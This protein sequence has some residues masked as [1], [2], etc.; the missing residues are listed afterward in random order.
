MRG[1]V[2]GTLRHVGGVRGVTWHFGKPGWSVREL[3]PG[4]TE[5]TSE[6]CDLMLGADGDDVLLLGSVERERFDDLVAMLDATRATVAVTLSDDDGRVLNA[7]SVT[8]ETRAAEEAA[9][10]E[11]YERVLAT[12]VG[13]RV[14][15]VTYWDLT[16]D[17]PT[18]PDWDRGDWH[19]AVMGVELTTDD[20]AVWVTWTDTFWP[21]GIEAFRDGTGLSRDD[22]NVW[23][24][25]DHELWRQRRDPIRGVATFWDRVGMGEG[26]TS[27]GRVP[28]PATTYTVPFAIRLDFDAGPVW[29]VAGLAEQDGSRAFVG[30]DEVMV[31]FAEDRVRELGIGDRAFLA[32]RA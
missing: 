6:W 8:P 15:D 2:S 1:T 31:V 18:D 4:E 3:S 23:P 17:E 11:R 12:L 24:A 32:P 20:G 13:L 9:K 7:A 5:A 25:G 26:R 21:Y 14:L 19:L 10:R 16:Y 22:V 27:D 29:F 28:T 30:G